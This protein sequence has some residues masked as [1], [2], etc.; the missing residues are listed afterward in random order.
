MK[1]LI[2]D[3]LNKNLELYKEI[4][5]FR[6]NLYHISLGGLKEGIRK[7]LPAI[8][9]NTSNLHL[10][11]RSLE[12]YLLKEKNIYYKDAL[13]ND[14]KTKIYPLIEDKILYAPD[15][16]NVE[17]LTDFES[18]VRVPLNSNFLIATLNNIIY[19]FDDIYPNLINAIQLTNKLQT[20]DAKKFAEN[21]L[22]Y[23]IRKINF[24]IMVPIMYSSF[25]KEG[26]FDIFQ[27]QQ[28]NPPK[29]EINN[30][31]DYL[32]SWLDRTVTLDDWLSNQKIN[33]IDEIKEYGLSEEE[34]NTI[35]QHR[36]L[37]Y[38]Q[39][40]DRLVTRYTNS[41]T[42]IYPQ[43]DKIEVIKRDLKLA[44][45]FIDGN[46]DD[47]KEKKL[48]QIFHI[49]D[50]KKVALDIDS[51]LRH[52]YDTEYNYDI[53]SKQSYLQGDIIIS[54]KNFLFAYLK[55][56]ERQYLQ[57]KNPIKIATNSKNTTHLLLTNEY[58]NSTIEAHYTQLETK[59]YDISTYLDEKQKAFLLEILEELKITKDGAYVLGDR[60]KSA[61]RGVVEALIANN[62]I[63]AANVE[64]ICRAIAKVIKMPM[65]S[66]LDSSQT[67]KD[68]NIKTKKLIKN[69]ALH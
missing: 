21:I 47:L 8:I 9:D 3:L 4:I 51:I 37:L 59:K 54:I 64:T 7:Y 24:E 61:L 57:I 23:I 65:S 6:N 32:N 40:K 27:M 22:E 62:L 56:A 34:E 53:H 5:N 46:I 35:H 67:S 25:M 1:E 20:E 17:D 26:K 19:D 52:E 31:E 66:K 41:L 58:I 11:R 45:D 39:L 30:K 18:W 42:G 63:P 43:N 36:F 2:A 28:L 69:N 49:N 14:L 48:K 29:K 50:W 33:V 15:S 12:E 10:F 55:E 13:I 16:I 60:K 38:N 44:S 68:Y